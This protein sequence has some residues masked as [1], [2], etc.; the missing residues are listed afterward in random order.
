M[1]EGEMEMKRKGKVGEAECGSM[2]VGVYINCG[3]DGFPDRNKS[4]QTQISLLVFIGFC[5]QP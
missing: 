2:G 3:T 1:I 4:L 5:L